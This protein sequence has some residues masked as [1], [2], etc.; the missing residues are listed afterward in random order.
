MNVTTTQPPARTDVAPGS[1]TPPDTPSSSTVR[2]LGLALVIGAAAWSASMFAY[3]PNP[4][5][6]PG[7]AAVD[8]TGF[9][10]QAGVM[11]LVQVQL[12]TRATG[13]GRKARAMLK[14]E[15]VLLGLAMVWSLVHGLFPDTRDD[16]WLAVLD[17]FWPL[18]MLGMFVIGVKIAFAGRW[19]GPARFWPLVAESWVVVAVPSMA[20]FGEEVSKY[21]AA[22]HLLVGYMTLGL[23]VAARPAFVGARD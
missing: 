20:I 18:S 1:P 7:M 6:D 9:L 14:V 15:R 11:G 3:G 4:D 21:V 17:V 10:F 19:T 22:S 16:V 8:L 5:G 2:N 23:I 12:M 13:S